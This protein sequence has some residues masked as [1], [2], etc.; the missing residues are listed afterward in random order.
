ME[1]ALN[2]A[3][4][5]A[6]NRSENQPENHLDTRAQ[7]EAIERSLQIVA[8]SWP[9]QSAVAV[10][11]FWFMRDQPF[12]QVLRKLDP[13]VIA[14]LPQSHHTK[15]QQTVIDEVSKYCSG[16]FDSSQASVQ[17]MSQEQP[18][19]SEWLRAQEFDFSIE[20]FGA[21]D[22]RE[23]LEV[24]RAKPSNAA[25][26][27]M[28]ESIRQDCEQESGQALDL[29][30]YCRHLLSGVSGWASRFRYIEW[31]QSLGYAVA[32][33]ART[34]DLLAVR[35]A[36]D[37][38]LPHARRLAAFELTVQDHEKCQQRIADR[39]KLI[40]QEN[41]YQ[42][43]L[44][45]AFFNDGSE[46][47]KLDQSLK[48]AEVNHASETKLSVQAAFCID[49][50]SE[51][52]R[53]ALEQQPC[54]EPIQS[55][56]T[57]GFAGFFGL[58]A[59]YRLAPTTNVQHRLPVLLSP[60]MTIVEDSG[61]L[62]SLM[63]SFMRS[64]RK[65]AFSSFL[66]VE[67]FGILAVTQMLRRTVT[68]RLR[69]AKHLWLPERFEPKVPSAPLQFENAPLVSLADRAEAALRHM[70]LFDASRGVCELADLVLIVGHGSVSTNNAFAATLDCGAC[71]GHAGDINARALA[72]ILN[73][74][75]VRAE[76]ARRS[77]LI[78]DTT[79]FMAAIHET[80]SDQVSLLE[81]EMV[82]ER[83]APAIA[84]LEQM[85]R[86][87]AIDAQLKR[88]E[89]RLAPFEPRPERRAR[90][91]AEVR[92]EWG[93]ANNASFIVAPRSRT[94]G[95]DLG[96]RAFLHDYDWRR[97][98]AQ[99]FKTL[100]LIMTAPMVVTNWINMQY[101][102]STVA[103]HLWGAGDKT[104]HNLV[105]ETG[106][107][108]GNGGDL[109]VGLPLQSVHDGTQFVHEPL[110]LSVVIEAPDSAIEAVI[111]KHEVVRDLVNNQWLF[112]LR[113]DDSGVLRRRTAAH[114][115]E[116]V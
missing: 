82:P 40:K 94:S 57:I 4:T 23:R 102:A 77:I 58:A 55:V 6:D 93:L 51:T 108:E 35:M 69:R 33:A 26:I 7:L 80:V 104:I 98:Q 8:P 64:L 46:S 24:V 73:D 87:A 109:R 42:R 66:Y 16:Y 113:C 1:A 30:D 11:P 75:S 83:Y 48:W 92:P 54:S 60:T 19:W 53:R 50:R 76:L 88:R 36:Y 81:R 15:L 25:I 111:A 2:T 63:P 43:Q 84:S 34:V 67:L 31:Q 86:Q 110:R 28:Y 62:D 65:N 96:G 44:A 78:S 21:N 85:F 116:E 56:K 39:L 68:G 37:F 59:D 52:L 95:L 38:C 29:E 101:Y 70:D 107:I 72:Q 27:A 12:E 45:R 89:T 49:V 22:I 112:I 9:L 20:A 3:Q 79:H 74:R 41:D 97:D 105:D 14:A 18:F 106:V 114:H 71:G 13:L 47:R 32:S 100:E 10:N 99:D 61:Q 115:Y 17:V 91:W 5:K 103:P 90:N